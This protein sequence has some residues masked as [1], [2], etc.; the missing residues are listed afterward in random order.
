MFC[1]RLIH[2]ADWNSE[3][4]I[5]SCWQCPCHGHKNLLHLNFHFFWSKNSVRSIKLVMKTWNWLKFDCFN[6]SFYF[7]KWK[8]KVQSNGLRV[9]RSLSAWKFI[10]KPG[11]QP[12]SFRGVKI[13]Q[14]VLSTSNFNV[15]FKNKNISA[16]LPCRTSGEC[17]CRACFVVPMET[18][19]RA[20]RFPIS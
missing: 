15:N 5:N 17:F 4:S 12:C 16:N 1:S 2:H 11:F 9:A 13:M 6:Q 8:L 20:P 3:H 19:G 7:E 18:A 14:N 10:L